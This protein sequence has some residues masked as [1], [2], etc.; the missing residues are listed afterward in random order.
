[1]DPGKVTSNGEALPGGWVLQAGPFAELAGAAL[2]LRWR[3]ASLPERFPIHWGFDGR[4][5]G[6]AT[7]SVAGVYGPLLIAAVVAATM[8]LFAG[9]LQRQ[10]RPIQ[11]AGEPAAAAE[12]RFRRAVLWTLL[13]TEYLLVT[14]S[15]WV[16]ML[17]LAA[18]APGGTPGPPPLAPL[19]A[20]VLAF[21]V[22]T[23]VVLV[24]TGKGLTGGP[25]Q[26]PGAAPIGDRSSDRCWRAGIFYLNPDDP[27]IFVEKRMGIGYT[28]NFAHPVSWLVLCVAILAPLAVALWVRHA[29]S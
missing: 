8:A 24:R 19:I 4:P 22:I 9:L 7:R 23:T 5:N 2:Y 14:I 18:A 25:H 27:A 1:V 11:H 12:R 15:T 26:G 10:S 17:P 16:S 20:L 29:A 3:W 21:V 13:G 6:W 28:L